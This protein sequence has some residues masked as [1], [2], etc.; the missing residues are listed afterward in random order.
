MISRGSAYIREK[1][2]QRRKV[3][4]AHN[5]EKVEKEIKEKAK[6]IKKLNFM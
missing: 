5:K 6:R 1:E 4:G 3:D 2:T